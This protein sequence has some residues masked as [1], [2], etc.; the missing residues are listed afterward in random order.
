M[1][2]RKEF[3]MCKIQDAI[4]KISKRS[5]SDVIILWVGH[6]KISGK[7]YMCDDGKCEDSIVT[8]QDAIV[9]CCHGSDDCQFHEFRW[10][11]IPSRAIK[12][13]TFKCCVK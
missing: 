13:F 12:A 9:E 10:I 6:K 2:L 1:L 4:Q 5:Q 7:L 11:N 8:L 3:S